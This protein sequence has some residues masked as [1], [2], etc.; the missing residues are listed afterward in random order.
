M[1]KGGTRPRNFSLGRGLGLRAGLLPA[2]PSRKRCFLG[3]RG[4]E[5]IYKGFLVGDGHPAGPLE[6]S[7]HTL[8]LPSKEDPVLEASTK[9]IRGT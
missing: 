7:R 4:W 1:S 9:C 3:R 2:N 6:I 8:V 5:G